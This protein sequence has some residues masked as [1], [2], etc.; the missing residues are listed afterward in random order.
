MQQARPQVI[1]LQQTGSSDR[2]SVEDP[3]DLQS[4]PLSPHIQW[5]QHTMEVYFVK[6]KTRKRQIF[7]WLFWLVFAATV[8]IL[9]WLVLPRFVDHGKHSFCHADALLLFSAC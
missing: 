4:S 6:P 1:P 7:C 3:D 2:Y 5:L 8:G 9:L